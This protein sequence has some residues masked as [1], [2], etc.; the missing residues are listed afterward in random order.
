MASIFWLISS[1]AFAVCLA[2]SFTSLATTAKP[3][4][5]SPAR[6]ASIV[7]FS[8][9]RLV[10]CAID[11]I[12]LITL[13]ISVLDS[14][15]LVT[16]TFVAS[17]DM[18]RILRHSCR[19]IGVLGDFADGALHLLAARSHGCHIAR[20]LFAGRGDY[21]GLSRGFLGV[22]RHLLADRGEFFRGR[23]QTPGHSVPKC[24]SC[25]ADCAAI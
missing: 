14:P 22:A 19:L 25:P 23:R 13:P 6:A 4:P 12:T 2:S 8:A 21:I 15:S 9:S 24:G 5:A 7:A 18:D 20:N 16:V 11:V 17:R 3:L 1:V 10:C